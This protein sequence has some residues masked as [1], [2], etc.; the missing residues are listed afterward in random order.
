MRSDTVSLLAQVDV[1]AAKYLQSQ[2]H[3]AQNFRTL[4]CSFATTLHLRSYVGH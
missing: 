1:Q 2:V 3:A 4:G